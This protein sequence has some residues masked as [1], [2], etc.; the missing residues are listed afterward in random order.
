[1]LL[2]E[3]IDALRQGQW[4]ELLEIQQEQLQLLSHLKNKYAAPATAAS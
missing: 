4:A 3:K 1:M 2:H